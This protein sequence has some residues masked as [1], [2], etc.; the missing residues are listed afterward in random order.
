MISIAQDGASVSIQGRVRGVLAAL[1]GATLAGGFYRFH[2][3]ESALDANRACN[4]LI[5][6]RMRE[7]PQG[8]SSF[9]T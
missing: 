2:T 1:G 6:M 3:V 4:E 9:P 5:L 7:N 8:C